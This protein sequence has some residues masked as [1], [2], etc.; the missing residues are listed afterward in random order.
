MGR[1]A[2]A[3]KNTNNKYVAIK[4][5]R[6][7]SYRACDRRYCRKALIREARTMQRLERSPCRHIL[8]CI[9]LLYSHDGALPG[10][11]QPPRS[12]TQL[13]QHPPV[14]SLNGIVNVNV[15]GIVTEFC[16]GGS[17]DRW[18]PRPRKTRVGNTEPRPLSDRLEAA[19]QV[20]KG[21]EHIH[22]RGLA[23]LDLKPPNIMLRGPGPTSTGRAKRVDIVIGDLGIAE[24]MG[25]LLKEPF[26]PPG[27]MAPEWEQATPERPAFATPAL[28]VWSFGMTLLDL[29]KGPTTQPRTQ[30][31]GAPRSGAIAMS[32]TTYTSSSA[33]CGAPS[34]F[35]ACFRVPMQW[36]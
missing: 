27:L 20:L 14:R 24:S 11:P 21:L 15:N 32:R 28:D 16:E 22:S 8:H 36:C 31:F 23:H 10:L 1:R 6:M 30:G 4:E 5:A 25:K 7:D 12:V 13:I 29:L 2:D 19:A 9:G 33:A 3:P 17:L 18:V 35:A 34:L 26:G